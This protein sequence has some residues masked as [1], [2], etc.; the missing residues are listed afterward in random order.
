M[1]P[2]KNILSAAALVV[3]LG[4]SLWLLLRGWT[5]AEL[6]AA[7]RGAKAGR[8]GVGLGLM[9]AFIGCEAVQTKATFRA[10]ECPVSFRRCL[11]FSL[12][13]FFFS[14]ITP[15]STGGQPAQV[16]YMTR[17]GI[18]AAYAA[19]DMLL[20]TACYQLTAM[21]YALAAWLICPKVTD[22]L[23]T[24]L[25]V[26]L[27]YGMTVTGVLTAAV[28]LLLVKPALARSLALAGLKFAARV[29]L[30]RDL[31]RRVEKLDALCADYRRAA[32]LL[33]RRKW[34]FV[35]LMAIC[36]VQMT[37]LY[38]VP[39]T[40]YAALGLSGAGITELIATQA[41][42]S[43]AVGT[44]PLPGAAG[45]GEGGFLAAFSALFPPELAP[46]AMLLSRSISFYLP[47]LFTAAATLWLHRSTRRSAA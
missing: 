26:L 39:W 46:A 41:L 8:I 23:G 34:L 43:V 2:R 45:A 36:A 47:L 40:V 11:S 18:P 20:L 4:V 17:R 27:G 24:G 15:S 35:L 33:K 1:N 37:A 44:L 13:G 29:R 6:M 28:V 31:P 32:E 5:T 30:I 38:A 12:A 3:L 42:L 16:Y 22:A 14:S 19:L 9:G 10:L 7:L 21:A 25:G